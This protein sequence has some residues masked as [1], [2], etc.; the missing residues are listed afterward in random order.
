MRSPRSTRW[1]TSRIPD[2][3]L[4]PTVQWE[5]TRAKEAIVELTDPPPLLVVEVVS[6]TAQQVLSASLS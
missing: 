4:L 5:A 3:V 1:D 6:D 2:V